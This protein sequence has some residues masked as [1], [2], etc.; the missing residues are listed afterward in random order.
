MNIQE[1]R[2]KFK[3]YR[4][5]PDL[6]TVLVVFLVGISSFLTGRLSIDGEIAPVFGVHEEATVGISNT[7]G[8]GY[9]PTQ[10]A[11]SSTKDV[12]GKEIPK[13][14]P[15][16]GGYVASKNGDK[17][18]LPWCAGALRIK[19]ENKVWFKTKEEAEAAGYRPASNCKG[20]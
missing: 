16:P 10:I 19:E 4:D 11:P 12:I 15:T 13:D 7:A 18:H 5:T 20:I 1:I 9:A 6:G 3:R 17:Y 2:E 8:E 14:S